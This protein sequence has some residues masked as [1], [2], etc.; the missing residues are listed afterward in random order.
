MA[1][2][3]LFLI[4]KH[5]QVLVSQEKP[6]GRYIVNNYYQKEKKMHYICEANKNM[7]SLLMFF[8]NIN[9]VYEITEF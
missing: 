6:A 7:A 2:H 1:S 9:E 3:F 5:K 4:E 8:N